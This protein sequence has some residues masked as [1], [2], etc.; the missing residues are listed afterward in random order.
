M[1][2]LVFFTLK[3]M[4]LVVLET[5]RSLERRK[6]EYGSNFV[7]Y[8]LIVQWSIWFFMIA[9]HPPFLYHLLYTIFVT[10]AYFRHIFIAVLLLDI[11]IRIPLLSTEWV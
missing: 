7:T 6:L 4:P 1:C 8:P 3:E 11:F 9:L 5:N 2:L 10:V